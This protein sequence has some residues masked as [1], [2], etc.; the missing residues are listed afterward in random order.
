[1]GGDRER[2]LEAGMAGC[3]HQIESGARN[4]VAGVTLGPILD[5]LE[6]RF[7]RWREALAA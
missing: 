6:R 5:D 7:T 3:A 4:G 2:C 1:M